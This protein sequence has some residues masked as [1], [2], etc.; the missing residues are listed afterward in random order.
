MKVKP[1]SNRVGKWKDGGTK[2]PDA[3]SP[4]SK[5]ADKPIQPSA[6]Y[7]WYLGP[8]GLVHIVTVGR[9][10][11]VTEVM[12]FVEADATPDQLAVLQAATE[13]QGLAK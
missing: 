9:F 12:S 13:D 6:K 7:K 10:N 5:S 3:G 4:K 1:Y 8:D 2:L 11:K